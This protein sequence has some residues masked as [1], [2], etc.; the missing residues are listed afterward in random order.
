MNRFNP[1]LIAMAALG[2]MGG[3]VTNDRRMKLSRYD[4]PVPMDTAGATFT[5]PAPR[6]DPAPRPADRAVWPELEDKFEASARN[7]AEDRL[8]WAAAKRARKAARKAA[9]RQFKIQN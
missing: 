2:G 5:L 7:D 6:R 8:A 3:T 9:A 1:L 4:D